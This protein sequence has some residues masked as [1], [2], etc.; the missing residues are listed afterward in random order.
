MP[1]APDD[2]FWAA[3]DATPWIDATH[4]YVIGGRSTR[5]IAVK[6][7]NGVR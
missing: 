4:V 6:D 3:V 2:A 7:I 5:G 1:H